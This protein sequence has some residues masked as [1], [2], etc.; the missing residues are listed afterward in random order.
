MFY[1]QKNILTCLEQKIKIPR[2][3]SI[4]ILNS[5]IL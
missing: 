5:A 1:L 3:T 2:E 4:K